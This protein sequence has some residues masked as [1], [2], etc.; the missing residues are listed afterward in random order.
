M[1]IV[2]IAGIGYIKAIMPVDIV[3]KL[4]IVSE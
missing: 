4:D 2:S 3:K 1:T